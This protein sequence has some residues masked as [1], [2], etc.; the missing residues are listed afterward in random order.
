MAAAPADAKDGFANAQKALG[1]YVAAGR[2]K[3]FHG[4][5]ELVPGIRSVVTPGH[6]PGHTLYMVESGGEKLLLWGDLMH[7]A[8]AQF[9][10]PS[11]SLRFDM[12]SAA[13]SEQRKKV[14]ADAAEHRYWVAG[15]HLPFP[16]IGHLRMNGSGYTYVHANYTT[17]TL[18][19]LQH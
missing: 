10:D 13:A 16:G 3:P 7:A 19:E 5:V 4:D 15:A 12:D 1:P 17:L 14:F 18:H 2:F 8:A 6:T 11:V 9:P